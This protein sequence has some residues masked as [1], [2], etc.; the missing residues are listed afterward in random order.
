VD[1]AREYLAILQVRLGPRLEV[2]VDIP[3]PLRDHPFPPNLLIL[4]VENAIKHGIEPAADGGTISVRARREGDMLTVDVADTGLGLG[5][6]AATAGE[7]VGL[8]NL[9]ERLAALYGPRGRFALQPNVPR[10]AHAILSLPFEA[11]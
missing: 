9:R 10:G 2:E 4:L 7:G 8:A 3:A 6:T 1:L 11:L 5:A